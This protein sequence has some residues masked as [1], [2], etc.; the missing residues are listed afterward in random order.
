MCTVKTIT[1]IFDNGDVDRSLLL[2]FILQIRGG[3]KESVDVN[4][5]RDSFDKQQSS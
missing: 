1:S 4:D 3:K 5:C 2:S